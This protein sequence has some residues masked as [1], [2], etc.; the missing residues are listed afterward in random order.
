MAFMRI[1]GRPRRGLGD[2]A[3]KKISDFARFNNTSLMDAI[4]KMEFTGKQKTEIDLFLKAFDFDWKSVSPEDAAERLLEDSGYVKMWTESKDDAAED[5]LKNIYELIN[6]TIARYDSLAEFLESASL[7][8]AD[9]GPEDGTEVIERDA[10]N[11]M[12]IHAAKGLEFNTVFMPAWE[13]GIFPNEKSIN[14]GGLEEERRLAYVAI[15]RAKRR[16][17]IT[18]ASQRMIFGQIGNNPPSRFIGEIDDRFVQTP[19]RP[20]KS[21]TRPQGGR[22]IPTFKNIKKSMVGSLVNHEEL[23]SGV[24]IE[25]DGGDI[26]TVAFKNIGIKKIARQFLRH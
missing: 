12:T 18:H 24:V 13:E 11:I 8:V 5:R 26:L 10:V 15:T 2:V 23:G 17:I 25:D 9:D 7:M 16:A 4:S 1:I 20:P 21:D 14:E 19:T 22:K 6:G 3:L